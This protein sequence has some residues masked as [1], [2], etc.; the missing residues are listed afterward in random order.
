MALLV[1]DVGPLETGQLRMSLHAKSNREWLVQHIPKADC[2][3]TISPF[4]RERLVALTGVSES[5]VRVVYPVDPL[6]QDMS[7]PILPILPSASLHGRPFFLTVG[8]VEPRKNH[9]GLLRAYHQLLKKWPDA[10]DLLCLG[11]GAW[12]F[13]DVMR[14]RTELDIQDKVLF[15]G[16]VSESEKIQYLHQSLAYLAPS[17]YEGFGY[18]LYE[19]MAMGKASLYHQGSSHE[20]FAH[21]FAVAVDAADPLS[22][23]NAMEELGK[24]PVWRQH[25]EGQSLRGIV[26]FQ[27]LCGPQFLD[28]IFLPTRK[29]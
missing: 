27:K 2:I 28:E 12:G 22:L 17:L 10:P 9:L 26:Q 21:G 6:Q 15:L 29:S 24:N 4:T 13:D 5:K 20:A 18:P 1:P 23:A 8:N 16:H 25:W 7:K 3:L 14:L 11:H 19:A